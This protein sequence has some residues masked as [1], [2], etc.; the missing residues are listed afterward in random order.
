MV[1]IFG[2]L[3]LGAAAPVW[4][5]ALPDNHAAVVA[6]L[7]GMDQGGT[8][9]RCMEELFSPCAEHGVASDAHL[10]C[11][12]SEREGWLSTVEVQQAAVTAELTTKGAMELGQVM[13]HW[14]GFV[15][16]KCNGVGAQFSGTGAEA[17]YVGCEISEMAGLIVELQACQGG[18]ST[19]QY[20]VKAE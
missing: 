5:E 11:L 1:R 9:E 2:V 20:C 7:S 15:A 3:A 18:R 19:A 12:M 6:C 10:A 4:A 16:N 17:A 13:G 8:W 14:F